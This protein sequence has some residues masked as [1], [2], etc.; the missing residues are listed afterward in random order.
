MS[1]SKFA[2]QADY[3]KDRAETMELALRNILMAPTTME[4]MRA[5]REAAKI[6]ADF[7]VRLDAALEKE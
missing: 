2:S 4:E 6:L 3:W 1:M 7:D 5:M